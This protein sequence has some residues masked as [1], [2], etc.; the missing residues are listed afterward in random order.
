MSC[1]A[2][3]PSTPSFRCSCG[4][5]V[6]SEWRFVRLTRP[7][8]PA[9]IHSRYALAEREDQ[10]RLDRYLV[11]RAEGNPLYAGELLRTLEEAGA[12][13]AGGRWVARGGAGTGTGAAAIAAGHRRAAVPATG[14][15]P[16]AAGCGGDHRARRAVFELW[17]TVAEVDEGTAARG[18]RSRGSGGGAVDAAEMAAASISGT[19]SCAKHSTRM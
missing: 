13:V 12:L 16:R 14:G 4:K 8:I 2:V 18:G 1:T 11:E 17:A 10:T 3:I 6:P 15:D 19:H 9:L 5:L 7:G